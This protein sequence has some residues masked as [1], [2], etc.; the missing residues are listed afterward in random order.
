MK[1]VQQHVRLGASGQLL[2]GQQQLLLQQHRAAVAL[3]GRWHQVRF[4]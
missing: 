2:E 1:H 4:S 3:Q